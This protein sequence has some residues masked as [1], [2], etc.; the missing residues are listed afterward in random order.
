MVPGNNIF[1]YDT[2][3]LIGIVPNLKRA[4]KFFL[5]RFFPGIVTSD[6]EFVSIDID[7]GLRRMAPFV[8]PLVEGKL[9]EQRRYQTNIFKPAYI[10]DKR[11]P[12]LRKPV[13]RMIGERIGGDQFGGAEREQAN[14]VFEMEDQVDMIDRRLEWMAISELTTGTVVVAGE[15][16]PTVTIDFG[17]DPN[18]TV[19]LSGGSRWGETGVSPASSIEDWQRAILK[20]S[21]AKVTD[22]VFDTKAWDLF[23][24]DPKVNL[25]AIQYPQFSPFGNRIDPGAQIER[26]AVWKGHWGQYDLWLY[27]DWYI[28]PAT[29]IEQ[30]ML[31]DYS[32]VMSGPELLGTRAFASILDPAHNYQALPYAPKTWVKEDP[33]QR[34]L[35]MQSAPLPIPSRVNASLG[36]TVR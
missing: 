9:V 4:Q 10:K 36:A 14:I 2:N 30:P 11:A 7:V 31:P 26:G 22:I 6:T 21:G 20:A 17:R 5:D 28:D 12:D 24:A 1:V 23:A 8:S 29:N 32:V 3:V 13:R 18:L 25:P 15:G 27:N 16:F 35:M 33:A 34:F 19:A